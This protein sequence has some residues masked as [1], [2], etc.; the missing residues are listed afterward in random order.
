M[1][2][3]SGNEIVE[4]DSKKQAIL[5]FFLASR[6]RVRNG[7]YELCKELSNIEE[8]MKPYDQ[9]IKRL[10]IFIESGKTFCVETIEPK[11]EA[12]EALQD[13]QFSCAD[14]LLALYSLDV[15]QV[16]E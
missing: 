1:K 2:F 10:K 12:E 9:E 8:I 3:K 13:L 14:A 16:V 5:K 15:E 4:A 6:I 11:N 7:I